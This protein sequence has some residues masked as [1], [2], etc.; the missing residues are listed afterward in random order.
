MKNLDH[1]P[2]IVGVGQQTWREPDCT[3]TPIDA[4]TEASR[5]ALMDSGS[6]Q[7]AQ[8]VDAVAMVRFI[9]DTDPGMAALFP[10]N[11]GKHA[12]QRLGIN[13]ARFFQ[14]VI[15]GNTPSA[16]GQSFC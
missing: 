9:A 16:F 5:L 7:L 3:R 15:G 6:D 2:I 12:A 8:E 13:N 1:L 10:R 11:P 4:I 14:G